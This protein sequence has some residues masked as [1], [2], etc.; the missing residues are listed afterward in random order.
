M[1]FQ[2]LIVSSIITNNDCYM[3]VY[4]LDKPYLSFYFPT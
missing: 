4:N 3:S 2:I 1:I